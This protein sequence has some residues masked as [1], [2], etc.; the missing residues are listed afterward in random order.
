MARPKPEAYAG[1]RASMSARATL[2]V[3]ENVAFL[4]Q[5]LKDHF[6]FRVVVPTAGMAD[7]Q[8]KNDLL[9]HRILL[10]KNTKDFIDDAPR[11]DYGIIALHDLKFIDP[12]PGAGNVTCKL[13]SAAVRKY[14]LVSRVTRFVLTLRA[15]GKHK[16]ETVE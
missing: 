7:D 10:T 14:K 11:F 2:V 6:N 15:S 5:P 1:G 16:L 13:I 8:I 4:A 12:Q 9:G 3:D